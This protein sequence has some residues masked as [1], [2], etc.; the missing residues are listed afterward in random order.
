MDTNFQFFTT[1][2]PYFAT[3]RNPVLRPGSPV[4]V[5]PFYVETF[6]IYI[7][8]L[9]VLHFAAIFSYTEKTGLVAISLLCLWS[10][11]FVIFVKLTSR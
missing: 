2:C 9:V 11:N 6:F 1:S 4:T 10:I 8:F 7:F 5:G 3:S